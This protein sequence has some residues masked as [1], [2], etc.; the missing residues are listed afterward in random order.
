MPGAIE[1]KFSFNFHSK[2][3][4]FDSLFSR[5]EWPRQNKKL[6]A[7][8]FLSVNKDIRILLPWILGQCICPARET[9]QIIHQ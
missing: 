8:P 1:T 6:L 9:E 4:A 3:H 5:K 2:L 7:L